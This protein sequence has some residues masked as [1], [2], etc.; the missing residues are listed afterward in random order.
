MPLRTRYIYVWPFD[1]PRVVFVLTG[2]SP[3]DVIC[4]VHVGLRYG[5]AS[6]A[7]DFKVKARS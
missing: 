3:L 4:V 6:D 7:V 1:G 2:C 5:L